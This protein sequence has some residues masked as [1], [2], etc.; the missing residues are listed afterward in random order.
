M[1]GNKATVKAVSSAFPFTVCHKVNVYK[2]NVL[3]PDK[4]D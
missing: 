1:F 4:A 3:C 2:P